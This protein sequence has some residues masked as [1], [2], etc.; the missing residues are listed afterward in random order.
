M[1]ALITH[2]LTVDRVQTVSTTTR[3][4]VQQDLLEIDVALVGCC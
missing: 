1:T 4:A 3:V 2:V